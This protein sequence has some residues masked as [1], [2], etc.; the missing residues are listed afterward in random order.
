MLNEIVKNKGYI[1]MP[2]LVKSGGKIFLISQR[3]LLSEK[4]GKGLPK[5]TL[6]NF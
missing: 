5:D 1:A 4:R 3:A 2:I 6:V